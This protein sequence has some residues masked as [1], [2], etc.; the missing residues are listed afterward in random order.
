MK[1]KSKE[2]NL[3]SSYIG[4]LKSFYW[5]M[6]WS[7]ILAF[8]ASFLPYVS[9]AL[10]DLALKTN[11]SLKLIL[12]ILF[13]WLIVAVFRDFL[14][15]SNARRVYA[16]ALG[17]LNNLEIDFVH[18]L[19]LLPM[20]FHKDKKIGEVFKKIDRAADEVFM[21]FESTLFE[22]L[23]S[24]ISLVIAIIILTIVD[25]RLSVILV[26]ASVLYVFIT[27]RFTKKNLWRQRE[28]FKVWDRAYGEMY[29]SVSNVE[30]VKSTA[31]EEWERKKF[32]KSYGLAKRTSIKWRADW[33]RLNFWQGLIFSVSFII[34]FGIGVLFLRSNVLTAGKLVM[35][36]GYV[37]LLSSPLSKLSD[38]YRRFKSGINAFRRAQKIYELPPEKDLESAVVVKNLRGE[39][40]FDNVSF[41]YKKNK[42]IIHDVSFEVKAGEKIAL[43]GES[44]VGK[45]TLVGLISKYYSPSKGRILIDGLNI[46]NIKIGSLR[47]GI[48]LVPQEVA[49]FND[50]IKNNIKYGKPDATDKEIIEAAK[51]AN[52]FEFIDKFPKKLNQV[53][54]ERGIKL[55]TGQKQRVAIARAVI[56][57][58][59]ILILD[60]AT[61][62][63]DSVSEKLVQEALEKLIKGRTTFIIAHRLS[64]IKNADKIIVL[65]NG[66]IA[67]MGNHQE[68][69]A[70]PQGIYRN[71]WEL[72]SA[73]QKVES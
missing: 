37:G 17:V 38:Q 14:N 10:V 73:I 4:S 64:T 47:N 1:F 50:T 44:G 9:G 58:P 49:L 22:F 12:G 72:Q 57:N 40:I 70:D 16:L 30:M 56:R 71:F 69:M 53:V 15:W 6:F 11:S 41:G 59:K 2:L 55:S 63:L 26:V 18:H 43:V 51:I 60:E 23:P 61:S 31:N 68:L 19:L 54:G 25:W 33:Q 66:R 8:V 29:D 34:V 42:T 36:T 28:M 32:T 39:I 3:I 20:S 52:A 24:I 7:L 67:E 46:R 48:A 21:F 62:A 27:I 65:E 45:T 35:F 13:L 5:G